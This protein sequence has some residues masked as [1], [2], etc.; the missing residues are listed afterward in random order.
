MNRHILFLLFAFLFLGTP[1]ATA[2]KDKR[3]KPKARK[4]QVIENDTLRYQKLPYDTVTYEK[5]GKVE[6][7]GGA[8]KLVALRTDS[9]QLIKLVGRGIRFRQDEV[10][11]WCDSAYKF[12]EKNIVEA[13]GNVRVVQNDTITLTCRHLIYDGNSRL[14]QARQEVVLRDPQ[15]T[16]NTD[17]LDY[18][19]NSKI[20]Y[21]Y[22]GG[23]I[24]DAQNRLY[25]RSG[26]YDANARFF[27]FKD[28]VRVLSYREGDTY[29]IESDTLQYNTVSKVAYFFGPTYVYSS[30]GSLYAEKGVY[31]TQTKISRFSGRARAENKEYILKGDSLYFDD[32]KKEGFAQ[33][34]AEVY[35]KKDSTF[36]NGDIGYF[37]GKKGLTHIY[38][39][40][41]IRNISSGDTLFISADTLISYNRKIGVKPAEEP[42]SARQHKILAFHNIKIYRSDIQAVCDSLV[43]HFSDS[44]IYFYRHPVLWNEGNQVLADS[45]RLCLKNNKP[46]KMELR[47]NCFSASRDSLGNFNQVKGRR[48]DAY[49]KDG[50]IE[51][52]EVDG[53]TEIIFFQLE[54]DTSLVGMYYAESAALKA[55]FN[56]GK[57]KRIRLEGD[58]NGKMIPPQLLQESDKRLPGFRWLEHL[59]PTRENVLSREPNRSATPD[60]Q[61]PLPDAKSG[62]PKKSKEERLREKLNGA[63]RQ[64]NPPP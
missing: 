56:E 16:L 52:V 21:Y 40:A 4:L 32:V 57:L 9:T 58:I 24:R 5:G 61:S 45:V 64:K 12:E 22:N 47:D 20:G 38:R 51:R 41:Y 35:T 3:P 17:F 34:N 55:F 14:L 53:N 31:E 48:M 13:F 1:A 10:L 15:M 6:L 42:D 28:S 63:G 43:Y 60:D 54:G 18:N 25:S 49:F 33:G 27:F 62:T 7:L 36:V 39:N 23:Q 37:W 50:S 29:R 2:Q 46:Y 11:L 8:D 26:S 44:A 59:R 19:L 30:D